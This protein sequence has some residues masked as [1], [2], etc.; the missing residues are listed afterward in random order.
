MYINSGRSLNSREG[1]LGQL[2]NN[3]EIYDQ[4]NEAATNVNELTRQLRPIVNDVRI[5]S[6]TIARHPGAIVRDAVKP[7]SGTKWVTE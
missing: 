2:I 7:R 1:T 3:R 5:F 6:D 4:I